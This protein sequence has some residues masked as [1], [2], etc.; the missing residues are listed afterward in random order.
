MGCVAAQRD[1]LRIQGG[2]RQSRSNSPS[3]T[4]RL[5][6]LWRAR[7]PTPRTFRMCWRFRPTMPRARCRRTRSRRRSWVA[8]W[9]MPPS[10]KLELCVMRHHQ[11]PHRGHLTVLA[12]R[13]F[14]F[15]NAFAVNVVAPRGNNTISPSSIWLSS[16]SAVSPNEFGSKLLPRCA[17][18]RSS[19]SFMA[20]SEIGSVHSLLAS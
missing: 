6:S 8:S 2:S 15:G 1:D 20:S 11:P 17:T 5:D 12:E 13:P 16:S 18:V 10:P 9:W 4:P 7:S 14:E 3:R 19:S